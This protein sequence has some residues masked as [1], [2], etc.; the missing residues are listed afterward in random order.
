MFTAAEAFQIATQYYRAGQLAPAQQMFR[1][2][3]ELEPEHAEALHFLGGISLESG[4]F[5][6]AIAYY[7][8]AVQC[9]PARAEYWNDLGA[10]C[11]AAA[12]FS[13]G[14]A[15]IEQALRLRPDYP[16]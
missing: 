15:A 4:D 3:L 2:V 13:E 8:R 5:D 11:I 14:A 1:Y 6:Q 7:R 12:R 9:S 10:V 16:E